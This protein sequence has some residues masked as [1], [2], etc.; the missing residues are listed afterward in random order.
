MPAISDFTSWRDERSDQ[1][2]L[3]S[4]ILL[5]RK[6]ILSGDPLE[7]AAT[8]FRSSPNPESWTY[9]ISGLQFKDLPQESLH[10]SRPEGLEIVNMRLQY[11]VTAPWNSEI[12]SLNYCADPFHS[13]NCDILI[14]SDK[15]M[16]GKKASL[17]C[18]WHFDR[19]VREASSNEP[20]AVHPFYHFQHGG[21][22][23]RGLDN[24]GFHIVLDPTRIAHPPLDGPL[25]IDFLL[26]NYFGEEWL[27]L[28]KITE[29]RRIMRD[30]QDWC[31]RPYALGLMSNW[32]DTRGFPH[33]TAQTLW[34][35]IAILRPQRDALIA[36]VIPSEE[37]SNKARKAAAREERRQEK[38]N[39]KL[40]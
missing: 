31:W 24:F 40:R 3:L 8:N 27:N 37:P 33:W 12:G 5:D 21:N 39:R 34:P 29:Y 19:D 35:Q 4:R 22:Q 14:T 11:R 38:A 7:S 2:R 26:S 6:L 1:L 25:I 16:D 30:S 32:D 23:I 13:I 18:A 20:N 17:R 28:R 9:S 15:V 10:H 36:A